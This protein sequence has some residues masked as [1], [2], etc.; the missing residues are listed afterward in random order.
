MSAGIFASNISL[1]LSSMGPSFGESIPRWFE[2]HPGQVSF[3]V[4]T[5]TLPVPGLFCPPPRFL[6]WILRLQYVGG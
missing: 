5:I 4:A 6:I 3:T 1:C 2:S